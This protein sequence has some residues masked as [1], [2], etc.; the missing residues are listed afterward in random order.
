M[1][2]I[3]KKALNPKYSVRLFNVA[4]MYNSLIETT[5]F[6]T[7]LNHIYTCIYSLID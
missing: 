7:L 5:I 3:V 2:Q 4:I 6:I 1:Y